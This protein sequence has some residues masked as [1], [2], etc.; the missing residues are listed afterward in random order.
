MEPVT[1]SAMIGTVVGYL[2]KKLKDNTSINNFLN[3]F[4]EATVNW[5]KPLFIID[6][7][8]KEVLENMQKDPADELNQKDAVNAIERGLRQ[9]PDALKLLEQMVAVIQQKDPTAIGGYTV[10]QTHLGSGDNVG[11]DKI[12]NKP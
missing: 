1:T 5:I 12:V 7:K 6:D 3:D 9:N 4:T 8:P 2:A 11:R 10:S